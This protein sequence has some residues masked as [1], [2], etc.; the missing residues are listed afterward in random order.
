[1]VYVR[2]IYKNPQNP[3]TVRFFASVWNCVSFNF[4]QCKLKTEIF[5]NP[6][7]LIYQRFLPIFDLSCE[8]EAFFLEKTFNYTENIE[9]LF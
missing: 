5:V 4:L 1:M 2:L 3:I 9:V 8:R 7:T 6:K